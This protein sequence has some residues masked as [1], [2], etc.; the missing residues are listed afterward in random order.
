[1]KQTKQSQGVYLVEGI[2]SPFIVRNTGTAWVA[3]DA[4]TDAACSDLNN[5]GVSFPT[6]AALIAYAKNF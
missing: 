5:W 4:T 1:M 3:Y 2:G 6:R